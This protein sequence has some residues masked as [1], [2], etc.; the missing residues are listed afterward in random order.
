MI[1]IGDTP[2]P[3]GFVVVCGAYVAVCGGVTC[4]PVWVGGV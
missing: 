3:A 2:D 4:V 1:T